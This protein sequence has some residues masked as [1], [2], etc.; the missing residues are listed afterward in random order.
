MFE[1]VVPSGALKPSRKALYE[2]LPFSIAIHA[3]AGVAAVGASI[4]TVVFPEHSPAQT[5]AYMLAGLPAPPPPPTQPATPRAAPARTA[6][7]PKPSQIVAPS[8]IPDEIPEAAPEPIVAEIVEDGLPEPVMG[9]ALGG[10]IGALISGVPGGELGGMV[11]GV[12]GS[13]AGM[14]QIGRDRPLPMYPLSQTYP[15]YPEDARVR[16]WE[17][18][19][20]VRYIIGRDGRVREVSVLKPP[21]RE[22]FIKGT[23]SAIRTWRFRPLVKDGKRQEVVHELTVFYRLNV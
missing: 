6:P 15:A 10:F 18:E 2:A 13:L 3:L 7:A 9:G 23:L 12:V 14:V 5:S 22:V 1:T 17:D 16:A 21:S 8:L 4:W 19:L 11:G 20:V